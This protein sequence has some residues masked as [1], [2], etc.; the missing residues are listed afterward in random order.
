[1]SDEIKN[2]GEGNSG[3]GIDTVVT[4]VFD[5]LSKQQI[6]GEMKEAVVT[7]FDK[8]L[9]DLSSKTQ[10]IN[11]LFKNI[12]STLTSAMSKNSRAA[13]SNDVQEFQLLAQKLD[14]LSKFSPEA[15]PTAVIAR[16]GLVA[17]TLSKMAVHASRIPEIVNPRKS[18]KAQ[19][20]DS[21]KFH[22]EV[23]KG[24]ADYDS[25][26]KKLASAT[27]GVKA[28]PIGEVLAKPEVYSTQDIIRENLN[29]STKLHEA[30]YEQRK[31]INEEVK[32]AR[33]LEV[34][35]RQ[36]RMQHHRLTSEGVPELPGFVIDV[37]T[38]N[39]NNDLL[40]ASYS[41]P[42]VGSKTLYRDVAKD[43][44]KVDDFNKQLVGGKIREGGVTL[45]EMM[46]TIYHDMMATQGGERLQALNLIGQNIGSADFNW[47]Q[48]NHAKMSPSPVKDDFGKLLSEINEQR[49]T[50]L[51]DTIDMWV[52]FAK[53][54]L[55]EFGIASR[56]GGGTLSNIA[57]GL[58]I[59][60]TAHDVTSDQEATALIARLLSSPEGR[61]VAKERFNSGGREAW[62][63]SV[64]ATQLERQVRGQ[65]PEG[66]EQLA[67]MDYFND[68]PARD[69]IK[70]NAAFEDIIKQAES[71][72]NA[73]HQRFVER[74][75]QGRI[76]GPVTLKNFDAEAVKGAYESLHKEPITTIQDEIGKKLSKSNPK[77]YSDPAS[78]DE[79]AKGIIGDPKIA[80]LLESIPQAYG[81]DAKG[82]ETF[83]DKV[84]K[85]LV[86]SIAV[87]VGVPDEDSSP[88]SLSGKNDGR[89]SAIREM[90]YNNIMTEVA[91]LAESGIP[92]ATQAVSGMQW[93]APGTIR[94]TFLGSNAINRPD[95]D[96]AH[97]KEIYEKGGYTPGI[98]EDAALAGNRLERFMVEYIKKN[99]PEMNLAFTGEKG[100]KT[101]TF[102]DV[103]GHP[104]AF[105][106]D[107]KLETP[108]IGE[109][110]YAGKD[111]MAH[112]GRYGVPLEWETQTNT[113]ALATGLN[114][115]AIMKY[116]L[117]DLTTDTPEIR[118]IE[119]RLNATP[120]TSGN[121]VKLERKLL[122][123][124][125]ARA[126][127]IEAARKLATPE[128]LKTG[129]WAD[130]FYS[131]DNVSVI[132]K[133]ANK[134]L[135][136]KIEG[137]IREIT[138]AEELKAGGLPADVQEY[139]SL[140]TDD[141]EK[142]AQEAKKKIAGSTLRVLKE[143]GVSAATTLNIQSERPEGPP[144]GGGG[145]GGGDDGG[146][147]SSRTPEENRA[148]FEAD[149]SVLTKLRDKA[150]VDLIKLSRQD[151]ML[152][153][154]KGL[155]DSD[156]LAAIESGLGLTSAKIKEKLKGNEAALRSY[157]D[158]IASAE[159]HREKALSETDYSSPEALD[160]SAITAHRQFRSADEEQLQALKDRAL[161][162]AGI[163]RARPTAASMAEADA[164]AKKLQET[165]TVAGHS[166]LDL[167][168]LNQPFKEDVKLPKA[169][170]ALEATASLSNFL[171][172]PTGLQ[173]QADLFNKASA[174][175]KTLWSQL[176]ASQGETFLDK[177]TKKLESLGRL[178]QEDIVKINQLA[179]VEKR[180]GEEASRLAYKKDKTPEEVKTLASVKEELARVKAQKA[181]LTESSRNWLGEAQA[182]ADEHK[183][184]KDYTRI[185]PSEQRKLDKDLQDREEAELERLQMRK[186]QL[187]TEIGHL[188]AGM[189]KANYGE[190]GG[191]NDELRRRGAGQYGLL[192]SQLSD[193]ASRHG[194]APLAQYTEKAGERAPKVFDKDI[195][196]R[197]A[198][199]EAL[200][201]FNDL[202]VKL[203]NQAIELQVDIDYN[204]MNEENLKKA[205]ANSNQMSK[206][207]L[208]G[209]AGYSTAQLLD[210]GLGQGISPFGNEVKGSDE[211][212]N[213][214]H[215]T[216]LREHYTNQLHGGIEYIQAQKTNLDNSVSEM[217]SALESSSRAKDFTSFSHTDSLKGLRDEAYAAITDLKN[218]RDTRE[219][220][221]AEADMLTK[222]GKHADSEKLLRE[223]HQYGPS[224]NKAEEHAAAKIDTYDK[225]AQE[226]RLQYSIKNEDIQKRVIS[227]LNREAALER[228]LLELEKFQLEYKMKEQK[229]SLPEAQRLVNMQSD[230]R[231][232]GLQQTGSEEH[233][234]SEAKK[235]GYSK[236]DI[237]PGRK[238]N[239]FVEGAIGLLDWQ[240]QW[241]SG[242][243]ILG[244]FGFALN[245]SIGFAKQFEAELK[246]MQLI[247]QA[248]TYDMS[249]L[250]GGIV[251]LT[252][253]YQ[254]SASELGQALVILG[255]AG[256]KAAESMQLLPG[257]ATLATATMSTLAVATD[258]TTTA[259]EAFNIPIEK[260]EELSNSLA[261]MTIESKLDLEKLGTT[262]NYVAETASAAGLD[263]NEIGT[264]M[265]LMSNAG[266]RASTIGTSL[267]S[268]IGS[269]L[270][271]T[272]RFSAALSAV[273]LSID[274]VNP[275]YNSFGEIM[276]K[277]RESGFN[278]QD[279][280][281]GLDK[282]IAGSI[283]TL[284][285]TSSQWDEFQNKITGTNRA[286]QMAEGQMD[287]FEAQ[288]KRLKNNLQL[289]L[290][291][292]GAP[293]L[294]PLKEGSKALADITGTIGGLIAK[295]PG[296]IWQALGLTVGAT[297]ALSVIKAAAGGIWDI[298]SSIYKKT[299]SSQ[300]S[301]TG[302]ISPIT[303]LPTLSRQKTPLTGME[304][305]LATTLTT[306]FD[307]KLLLVGAGLTAAYMV[308]SKAIDVLSGEARVR[309]VTKL[310]DKLSSEAEQIKH[311]IELYKSA[312][313]GT[314]MWADARENLISLG[315]AD[316][317]WSESELKAHGARARA[318]ARDA[319]EQLLPAQMERAN[320]SV[321]RAKY[322]ATWSEDQKEAYEKSVAQELMDG[323]ADKGMAFTLDE[324]YISKFLRDNN[325]SGT[326]ERETKIREEF[327]RLREGNLNS[328][329][330][331]KRRLAE[332]RSKL[333]DLQQARVDDV[334]RYDYSNLGKD[335]AAEYELNPEWATE[336][337]FKEFEKS[338]KAKHGK[339]TNVARYTKEMEALLPDLKEFEG[340]DEGGFTGTQ[341]SINARID[342]WYDET[343]DKRNQLKA[344]RAQPMTELNKVLIQDLEEQLKTLEKQAVTL[345]KT[346]LI[347]TL[348]P[349]VAKHEAS[350]I[351]DLAQAI[352]TQG[353]MVG[354]VAAVDFGEFQKKVEA[355]E[356]KRKTAMALPMAKD[357]KNSKLVR[358]INLAF[359]LEL[360]ELTEGEIQKSVQRVNV[361]MDKQR[362]AIRNALAITNASDVEDFETF[363][364]GR[365]VALEMTLNSFD[366]SAGSY[367]NIPGKY[368]GGDK[369]TNL[370]WI[371]SLSEVK[372]EELK[373]SAEHDIFLQKSA[374]QNKVYNDK[375]ALIEK[376]LQ[377]ELALS[378]RQ[379]G[380]DEEIGQ[381]RALEIKK[382]YADE[383]SA[384]DKG[385]REEIRQNIDFEVQQYSRVVKAIQA[386]QKAHEDTAASM[387]K[388]IAKLEAVAGLNNKPPVT[389][390]T[391]NVDLTRLGEKML[392]ARRAGD[393][394]LAAKY[395]E[396]MTAKA[397]RVAESG[398]AQGA[399]NAAVTMQQFR[400][401]DADAAMEFKTAQTGV[402]LNPRED[403][404]AR[405]QA[406]L[407]ADTRARQGFTDKNDYSLKTE[408]G[409]TVR[410]KPMSDEYAVQST[411][412]IQ[413]PLMTD[414]ERR[415]VE[416]Q[417]A[418][419]SGKRGSETLAAGETI[420]EVAPKTMDTV[421]QAVRDHYAELVTDM[422]H[423]GEAMQAAT[424]RLNQIAEQNAEEKKARDDAAK[425]R[426]KGTQG[427]V[428]SYKQMVTVK[429]EPSPNFITSVATQMEKSVLGL[430]G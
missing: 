37:E 22:E 149:L 110:K 272:A 16:Q 56:S 310:A 328:P 42:Q 129:I 67:L 102:G 273:G 187:E 381:K 426:A 246:N 145:D 204:G 312:A 69:S 210:M 140:L 289:A 174:S 105:G 418:G 218:L 270:S 48:Q 216:R 299:H 297:S 109:I 72:A 81:I 367:L 343:L 36:R 321:K 86:D 17:E 318:M 46:T 361:H 406:V 224:I 230:L 21:V 225:A 192:N 158:Q 66:K 237:Q 346:Q 378:A 422:N 133:A 223:A 1:M 111:K 241:L 200:L 197:L 411:S 336:E 150:K 275:R 127:E 83:R 366:M 421:Y 254:Y 128:E 27:P 65:L 137:T 44:V 407:A 126:E 269:L 165:G 385:R 374:M 70:Y 337:A 338:W 122:E 146:Y 32:A 425:E 14:A 171:D 136:R 232:V 208:S 331:A 173:A 47:L 364:S 277:L 291:G 281:E 258:V 147:K 349:T 415:R 118:A 206:Y 261:A 231:R 68:R 120:E 159:L 214:E 31:K 26:V 194:W 377:E 115:K 405:L 124:R 354:E 306:M 43:K 249:L 293:M 106:Y 154:V 379:A 169:T 185:T 240:M 315:L 309:N 332:V 104:D 98:S 176:H 41:S 298:S 402:Y 265:G 116:F 371:P 25:S 393:N 303:G 80:K 205:L 404:I 368:T 327:F 76:T 144:V 74:L 100:Q 360:K 59:P 6:Q 209:T 61:A 384:L 123:M 91:S 322:S 221:L 163:N 352:G 423:F 96:T 266:V 294:E 180:L 234:L 85:K 18:S 316:R 202:K 344:L 114:E 413:K 24:L 296:G 274:E 251:E 408:D 33:D 71:N 95:Y 348:L 399:R 219:H 392:E 398:D 420:N 247:T 284:V 148:K 8:L 333:R 358:T 57:A 383:V 245:N 314:Q 101:V 248:N 375:R 409:Q 357:E 119:D 239:T 93:N 20:I 236:M 213:T 363:K 172:K 302:I 276:N 117:G 285:N 170:E 182:V 184:I 369:T 162:L 94:A 295:T 268:V 89:I 401:W 250:V 427:E 138:G 319:R 222:E 73:D 395:L 311:N 152:R 141:P 242:I 389:A 201:D 13:K 252:D 121:R 87:A 113:Y 167:I 90:A 38:A 394:P 40:S 53:K 339:G 175:I 397:D 9:S 157:E 143:P 329:D 30:V 334:D 190:L 3:L 207:G 317:D 189:T 340:A 380:A 84:S 28:V 64:K 365:N 134:G 82:R 199:K 387:D 313:Y 211:F 153:D 34:K 282:R 351:E 186:A 78:L 50:A 260:S 419:L 324:G 403:E 228:E 356:T 267:R 283:T 88:K 11:S 19:L 5:P 35:S 370:P 181:E 229:L 135:Q 417:I 60:M 259:V 193:M 75:N 131:L 10:A 177:T 416:E 290:G 263:V 326:G 212:F 373:L 52:D 243:A 156:A 179:D 386:T 330:H 217:Y 142:A 4:I 161:Q 130:R 160:R 279:A 320:S 323:L 51:K 244:S 353:K 77:Q 112:I 15:E 54:E 362:A 300:M 264:A 287:T 2:T 414:A 301:E 97:L 183:P 430:G 103:T 388:T 227:D 29:I 280:F 376:Q 49:R 79:L 107:D 271:P 304:K 428:G 12:S 424:K 220:L 253:K 132:D 307:P 238:G 256:F 288:S 55:G 139:Y 45:D 233:V 350:M 262:F 39:K 257:I 198:T 286:T 341:K 355:I 178:I 429:V 305:T 255:Q 382:K 99:H 62:L 196:V 23:K 345:S 412:L 191:I 400:N 92:R 391:L 226:Q 58:K 335:F 342:K 166:R 372:R 195:A 151:Q 164:I 155:G 359:D 125:A 390:E 7:D 278:V 410:Y 108:F 292:L 235:S 347:T 203:Q 325:M 215:Y 188:G 63:E 308:G 168:K 396:E